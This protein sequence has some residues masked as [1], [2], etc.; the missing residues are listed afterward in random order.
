MQHEEMV[1][2]DRLEMADP[3]AERGEAERG[4]AGAEELFREMSAS[5]EDWSRANGAAGLAVLAALEGDTA[6]FDRLLGNQVAPLLTRDNVELHPEMWRLLMSI[7]E[8]QR[9]DNP[10][11]D[12]LLDDAGPESATD[13]N[14]A[15]AGG[16]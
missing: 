15:N 10:T 2:A 11:L 5:A 4:L 8:R 16:E 7:R 9:L 1:D 13:P 12:S 14:D 6:E 3:D